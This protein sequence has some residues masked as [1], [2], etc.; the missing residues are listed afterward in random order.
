MWE[1]WSSQKTDLKADPITSAMGA[2]FNVYDLQS[3][4]QVIF[5]SLFE[6]MKWLT[7]K[8]SFK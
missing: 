6:N 5:S 3:S 4:V 8:L 1:Q 7:I 2:S